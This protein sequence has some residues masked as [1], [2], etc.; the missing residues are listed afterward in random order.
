MKTFG[1]IGKSLRHSFS[2]RYFNEKFLKEEINAQYLNFELNH[3]SD[4]QALITKKKISG[5]NV[6]I[7]YKKHIIPLL[8]KIS[9][10]A[11]EIGAVNTI[12]FINGKLIGYN[13]D[14]MGFTQSIYPILNDRNKALIL[15]NG[16]AA[17][18]I[19]VALK[20]LEITYKTV[21][22]NSAFDYSDITKE[23]TELHSIII[24]TTP[25]GTYPET[26][27]Y[28]KIPYK[29][30]NKSHLLYDLVYNPTETKFL[31]YGKSKGAAIKNGLE[32][33]QKQAEESWNIWNL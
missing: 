27:D 5:L 25:I 22:R 33:L 21:N 26:A 11:K 29:Y 30:L 17:S 3:I 24:N 20:K 15:G 31:K 8:D 6:T 32:M 7:P 28:P 18:A 1:L 9:N 23:I 2:F 14:I 12:K 19:K 16:G 13:T 10:E 4:F